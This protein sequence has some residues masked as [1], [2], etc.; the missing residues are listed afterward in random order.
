MC[1]LVHGLLVIFLIVV[2][3]CLT[4]LTDEGRV[5]FYLKFKGT[6]IHH[7]E[8]GMAAGARYT[9]HIASADRKQ[10]AMNTC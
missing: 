6:V 8:E 3:K 7:G 10:R 1:I 2:A 5:Y 9:G 4:K